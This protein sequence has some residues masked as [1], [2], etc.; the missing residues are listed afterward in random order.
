MRLLEPGSNAILS[1]L[2]LD[3]KMC[4]IN[5]IIVFTALDNMSSYAG[6]A[7]EA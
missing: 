4:T 5:G 1:L 3:S 6:L 2:I 7:L